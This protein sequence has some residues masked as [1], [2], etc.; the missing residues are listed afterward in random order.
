MFG[1]S[2]I[3]FGYS[4]FLGYPNAFGYL[5]LDGYW[6]VFGYLKAYGVGGQNLERR[7]VERSN[8]QIFKIANIKM[9]KDELFDSFIVEFI[10][11]IFHK[12]FE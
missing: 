3:F 7:N 6:N 2:N 5:N 10:F 12:L 4:N 8:F 9:T 1:Y 11:L